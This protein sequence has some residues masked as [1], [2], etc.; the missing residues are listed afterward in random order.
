MPH[1]TLYE[2][3]L[4]L[5]AMAIAPPL[6]RRFGIGTVLGYLLAGILLGPHVF[7]HFF[8]AY[9]AHE[10]LELSEFGI[11]L[12]L[13][14]IGLELRPK[15]L[16]AMRNAIFRLGGAQVLLTGLVLAAAAAVAG[17]GAKTAL[18]VGLV[19]A[20]SSTAFALQLME[21]QG[22]LATRHGRLGFA[23]LLFQDLAAIP[24]IA[25]VPLFATTVTEASRGMDLAATARGI[26]VIVAVV[27]IGHF[28]LDKMLRLVAR[29]QV[30]EAMTAAGLLTV[31]GVAMLMQMAGLSAALGAFI[32]GALLAESSYRHQLEADLQPFQG[33]LLGLF[34]TAVGMS[35]DLTILLANPGK[36]LL[37]A[38]ALV[39]TKTLILYGLGR[40]SGL[41]PRAA[42]RLGLLLSQGGEF[43]FV[44]LTAS[45]A[46]NVLSDPVS[47]LLILVV[48]ISMAATPLLLQLEKIV[49]ARRRPDGVPAYDDNLP[50]KDEHV[51]IAG[52][53]RYGQI[54]AR[55]L[56]GKKIPFIALEISS[57]QVDLVQ[58]FGSRAFYGD[59]SRPEILEAAQIGK[60]RAFV[61]AIDNIEASLRAAEYVRTRHPEVPVFARAR[62]RNHA[63]QL[64]DVGVTSIQR[65]TFLSAL[66]TTREILVG[67]GYA[68]RESDRVIETFRAHDQRRVMEDYAHYSDV[69]KLQ[70]KARSDVATLEQ[71]FAEDAEEQAR[72][73]ADARAAA[74]PVKPQP[75]AQKAAPPA[76]VPA[77]E[78]SS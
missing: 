61:I 26:G 59:A 68:E 25:F 19:L 23:V 8:T 64:L 10:I 20:L 50:A 35:M 63:H 9:D 30:K 69:E 22:D 36:V 60:A 42:R 2:V 52:F 13:F 62:N 28:A 11:V 21:E 74:R 43:A 38:A 54:V 67:L 66:E 33:L 48:T 39:V 55:I 31:V 46:A 4:L 32:S 45:V 15:R 41:E 53:G 44:L 14:L 5:A 56:R 70:A 29:T 3:V 73:R 6:A 1:V 47:D 27:L 72:E 71:L 12:L 40:L 18:F 34:F 65:E 37:L 17:L 77:N 76:E 51:V 24:L 49:T 58:K 75:S 57:E 78:Q 16:W 7:R